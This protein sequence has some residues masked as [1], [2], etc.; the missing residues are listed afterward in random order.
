MTFAYAMQE[1]LCYRETP[2]SSS[3]GTEPVDAHESPRFDPPYN[4]DVLQRP[5]RPG[6]RVHHR[7]AG[8]HAEEEQLQRR[9]RRCGH[10][11]GKDT[12][13]RNH[14]Q[15]RQRATLEQL[16][17]FADSVRL[18]GSE[19][20]RRA[21]E[22]NRKLICS[23]LPA[24][25]SFKI[26]NSGESVDKLRLE[27]HV[28]FLQK[29]LQVKARSLTVIRICAGPTIAGRAASRAALPLAGALLSCRDAT[30]SRRDSATIG[31]FTI[32]Y[33]TR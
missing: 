5:A 20:E 7:A 16:K 29:L 14:F 24:K 6:L 32:R 31:Q 25:T 21:E 2:H 12:D 23:L 33:H 4:G 18:G 28:A 8:G 13:Y 22:I 30:R 1:E 17:V 3:A 9:R 27:K 10:S 26:Q 15:I 11:G 19:L